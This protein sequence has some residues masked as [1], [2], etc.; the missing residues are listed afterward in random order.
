[1]EDFK[2]PG[3]ILSI[4]NT[5]Y[6]IGGTIL[7]YR[8]FGEF[9]TKLNDFSSLVNNTI[10]TAGELKGYGTQLE[11]MKTAMINLNRE[12]EQ[13]RQDNTRLRQEQDRQ[14]DKIRAILRTLKDNGLTVEDRRAYS[15]DRRYESY[16]RRYEPY[17]PQD[18]RYE[19]SYMSREPEPS[20]ARTVD[21]G[22]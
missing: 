5:A 2:R 12:L 15:P 3:T 7:I 4:A 20:K 6:L 1:M 21:L 17:S 11:A 13:L 8:K 14:D 18:R 9:D 22:F 10:K 16:E 19:P